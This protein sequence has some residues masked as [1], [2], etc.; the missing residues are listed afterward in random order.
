MLELKTLK[1]AT[2]MKLKIILP[3]VGGLLLHYSTQGNNMRTIKNEN[4]PNIEQKYISVLSYI[5]DML[6]DK[7][8]TWVLYG[9]GSLALRGIDFALHD[10]DILT[11]EKGVDIISNALQEYIIS[12]NTNEKLRITTFNIDGITIECKASKTHSPFAQDPDYITINNHQVPL[13]SLSNQLKAYRVC[14][15]DK[16]QPKIQAIEKIFNQAQQ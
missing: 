7:D 8:I 12:T 14:N 11:D 10:V 6:H 4:P 9:G 16:D 5:C 1:G 15:R 13:I 2:T 3:L